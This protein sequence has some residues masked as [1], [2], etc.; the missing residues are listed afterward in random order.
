[1][2]F[3]WHHK[4]PT[5]KTTL[6][7]KIN[8]YAKRYN[9]IYFLRLRFSSGDILVFHYFNVKIHD[10]SEFVQFIYVR[11]LESEILLK[12]QA[13]FNNSDLK[14]H[15]VRTYQTQINSIHLFV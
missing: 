11:S 10:V 15:K 8:L 3:F 12:R 14:E 7:H 9:F 13:K 5:P 4:K 1:M 6:P 2:F